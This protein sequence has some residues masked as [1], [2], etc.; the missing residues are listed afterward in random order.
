MTVTVDRMNLSDRIAAFY[1]FQEIH[2][3]DKATSDCL[4]ISDALS[5]GC[6]ILY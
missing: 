1:F 5:V 3:F 2:F 4:D 6:L